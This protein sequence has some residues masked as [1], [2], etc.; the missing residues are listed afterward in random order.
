MNYLLFYKGKLP[1]YYSLCINSILSVD[2][3]AKIIFC[4]DHEIRNSNIDFL[5]INDIT[6]NETHEIINLEVYEGTTYSEKE[7]PLWLNSLLRV[8]YLRDVASE[9]SLDQFIHFDL[10]VIIYKSFENINHIFDPKKL[11]ITEHIEDTPIFGYSYFPKLE[12]INKLCSDLKDYLLYENIKNKEL[13]NFRPLNEMELLSIV[14]EKN[15]HLFNSLPILPYGNQEFIFDP[16]TYG[17][18]FGGLP[19]NSNSLFKRRHISLSHI[20]GKEISSKR[21]KPIFKNNPK[22]LYSNKEIDIVNLHIH[23]KQLSKFLPENY[24]NVIV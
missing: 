15:D 2:I 8:F 10:D 13:P 7:N 16:A 21:I 19:A 11:N 18:Y 12:I 17:Q 9:L 1:D 20:A 5:H 3:E 24:K 6:S 14:K 22:V 4:G 23:S